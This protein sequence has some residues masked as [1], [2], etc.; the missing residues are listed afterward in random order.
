MTA[1]STPITTASSDGAAGRRDAH[2]FASEGA[3]AALIHGTRVAT[4]RVD[5]EAALA[6]GETERAALCGEECLRWIN[7]CH[8]VLDGAYWQDGPRLD[9]AI[10]LLR[11]PDDEVAPAD[12]TVDAADLELRARLPLVLPAQRTAVGY[13]PAADAIGQI[14]KLRHR[15]GLPSLMG[16]VWSR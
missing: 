9:L 14:E 4:N 16:T 15:L 3:V 6:S 12:A 13:E 10:A 5:M 11:P 7:V 2:W 8:A 1:P